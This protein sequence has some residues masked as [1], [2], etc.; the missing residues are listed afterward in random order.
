MR[1][2]KKL[3]EKEKNKIKKIS[4]E[5]LDE[6]KQKKLKVMQWSYKSVTAAVF[7]T[8]SKTLFESLPFPICQTDDMDLETNLVNDHL[9]H[10]Y[11]RSGMRIYEPY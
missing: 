1:H 8:V 7:N 9:K 11:Y 5:L 2:G 10:Q 6:L 4:I 3:E